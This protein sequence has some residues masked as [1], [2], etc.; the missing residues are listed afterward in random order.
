[1]TRRPDQFSLSGYRRIL[2]KASAQ[3]YHFQTFSGYLQEPRKKAILLRHDVDYSLEYAL[4][5][6][7][8]EY[9]LGVRSTYFVRIH[10]TRYNL[11]DRFNYR[12]LKR[13]L[14]WGF[15]IGVHQEVCNFAQNGDDATKLLS[16]EKLVIES[17]LGE[18]VYGVATHLPRLNNLPMT[19]ELIEM[20]GFK[21]RPDDEIFNRDAIF[22][23][24]SQNYWKKYTLDEV[25]GV[26]D[27]L[28]ANI[29]PVWWVGEITDDKGL[30][31]FLREGN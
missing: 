23:S 4:R 16:R 7:S 13:L 10:S 19:D 24:D 12:R 15:E 31:E 26:S 30:I 22:V 21:Y 11:F 2:L 8:L 29:H 20:T 5:M 3:G 28:L 25:L 18:N 27:K 6:A 14:R 1:M 9:E 17:I